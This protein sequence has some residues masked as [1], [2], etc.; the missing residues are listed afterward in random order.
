MVTMS[1]KRKV[2]LQYS[3]DLESVDAALT[4]AMA[5]LDKKNENVEVLLRTFDP[6]KEPETAAMPKE[7]ESAS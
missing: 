5:D 3:D 4:E 2:Q 6:P 7:S 1:N